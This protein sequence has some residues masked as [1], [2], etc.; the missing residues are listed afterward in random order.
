VDEQARQTARIY[1]A[2]A[3]AYDLLHLQRVHST[4]DKWIRSAVGEITGD[5]VLIELGCGTGYLVDQLGLR[6][7]AY[8]GVDI[9][10]GMLAV[11][12]CKHPLHRA[13]CADMAS[14][15]MPAESAQCVVGLWGALSY[16]SSY[17]SVLDEA[18]R[19]LRPGGRL[20]LMA[21]GP[22]AST[23]P[24]Y[25]AR[26]E[27][28]PRHVSP[29]ALE[30]IV[31]LAGFQSVHTRGVG[32]LGDLLPERWPQWVHDRWFRLEYETVGRCNRAP[33]YYSAVWA[34]KSV[35]AE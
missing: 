20:F 24:T 18:M 5:G 21:Y 8:F 27:L 2:L 16:H 15:P 1:D 31:C 3:P 25:A 10:E 29:A 26:G 32:F 4:E 22:R 7:A 6:P 17:S 30:D 13:A 33:H 12:R 11:F 9:S 23:R 19:L 34:T 14:V 28:W 35:A